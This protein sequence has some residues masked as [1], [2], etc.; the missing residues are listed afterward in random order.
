MAS[1]P[2][3]PFP[4]TSLAIVSL[5]LLSAVLFFVPHLFPRPDSQAV[6]LPVDATTHFKCI[7]QGCWNRVRADSSWSDLAANAGVDE[8]RLR[9]GNPQVH[10]E[11]VH[12][13][14]LIRI[15]AN[16]VP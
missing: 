13:G 16:M 10:G 6:L 12:A 2:V 3:R 1:N 5:S 11:I 8:A 4:W 7:E 9:S 14:D 15:K